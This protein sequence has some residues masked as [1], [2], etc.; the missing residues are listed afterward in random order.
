VDGSFL[1]EVLGGLGLFLL[2]G[3][4]ASSGLGNALGAWLRER[5]PL[6]TRG[7]RG[8][9]L[10]G[11]GLTAALGFSSS[12]GASAPALSRRWNLPA[13]RCLLFLSGSALACAAI[14]L[15]AWLES[16]GPAVRT[17]A[18]LAV[19]AGM[20]WRLAQPRH[21]A[22]GEGLAGHGLL[23][24]GLAL[25]GDGFAALPEGIFLPE[26][27]GSLLW[28][29]LAVL[30]GAALGIG[31]GAPAAAAVIVQ[32]AAA[33]VAS[34][35][36]AAALLVGAGASLPWLT[37]RV[38]RL[39]DTDDGVV[40]AFH[41][42]LALAFSVCAGLFLFWDDQYPSLLGKMPGGAHA[43]LFLFLLVG[44]LGATPAALIFA[45]PLEGLV[46]QRLHATRPASRLPFT[47]EPIHQDVPVLAV[48]CLAASV[49]AAIG[50][51]RE[52]ARAKL[53][54]DALSQARADLAQEIVA[55]VSLSLSAFESSLA[56]VRWAGAQMAGALATTRTAAACGRLLEQ[57]LAL[58]PA[59]AASD[60]NLRT[61]L[62]LAAARVGNLIEFSTRPDE[63]PLVEDL[64]ASRDALEIELLDLGIRC[65]WAETGLIERLAS[66]RA[67]AR[68]ALEIGEARSAE[69]VVEMPIATPPGSAPEAAITTDLEQPQAPLPNGRRHRIKGTV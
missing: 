44:L 7:G 56:P 30:A 52:V 50:E 39:G 12:L 16:L 57:L 20:V 1:A 42:A 51:V 58:P 22:L 31:I 68:E 13:E 25:L 40:A 15:L 49:D 53:N 33:G 23:L 64:R 3:A 55:Q 48:E 4:L 46:R 6:W 63:L 37:A 32:S 41:G 19:G 62:A 43:A 34:T 67:L 26:V 21:A 27:R 69:V 10:T 29:P 35:H 36:T 54:G 5:V 28:T 60:E 8:S 9:L 38:G 11:F 66:L 47:L 18:C 59:P 45:R 61:E 24:L 14:P 65:G 17:L 2:G